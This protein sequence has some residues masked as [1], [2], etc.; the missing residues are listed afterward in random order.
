MRRVAVEQPNAI[1]NRR[2]VGDGITRMHS[3]ERTIG[4]S[5]IATTSRTSSCCL[6]SAT[7]AFS[8]ASRTC[9]ATSNATS[10]GS[11]GS[12]RER[13]TRRFS[14]DSSRRVSGD[15]GPQKRT[16]SSVMRLRGECGRS[17]QQTVPHIQASC[18]RGSVVVELRQLY[19]AEG[20]IWRKGGGGESGAGGGPRRCAGVWGHSVQRSLPQQSLRLRAG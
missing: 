19:V 2:H 11:I 4:G 17:K 5:A 8:C 10:S 16:C 3:N 18:R 6:V 1:A 13:R 7:L 9:C 14:C 20:S 15:R 12:R